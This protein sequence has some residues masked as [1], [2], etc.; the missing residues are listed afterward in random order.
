MLRDTLRDDDCFLH[1]GSDLAIPGWGLFCKSRQ[2]L[3]SLVVC[4]NRSVASD[5]IIEKPLV[6]LDG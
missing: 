3:L 5:G 1:L 2:F 6:E 4:L